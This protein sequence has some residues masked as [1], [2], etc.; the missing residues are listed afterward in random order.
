MPLAAIDEAERG[1][2]TWVA[3]GADGADEQIR[4]KGA[5]GRLLTT[6]A[7]AAEYEEE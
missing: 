3:A 1:S 5:A 4:E 6:V 7:I 2:T